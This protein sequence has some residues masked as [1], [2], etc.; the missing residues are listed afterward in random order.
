MK[1]RLLWKEVNTGELQS[2]DLFSL[3]RASEDVMTAETGFI[4]RL[5]KFNL[6]VISATAAL[7]STCII[8]RNLVVLLLV[9]LRKT[10]KQP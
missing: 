3:L 4:E 2:A 8:Y 1:D 9:K 7:Q 5:E 6:P 10:G